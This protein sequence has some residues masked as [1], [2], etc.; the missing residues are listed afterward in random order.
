MFTDRVHM[1]TVLL[2]IGL[3]VGVKYYFPFRAT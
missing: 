1:A 3:G 2:F